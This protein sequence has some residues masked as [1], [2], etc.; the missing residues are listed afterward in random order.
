MA[1][2][3]SQLTTVALSLW[4]LTE[5]TFPQTRHEHHILTIATLRIKEKDKWVKPT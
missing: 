1:E 5:S 2:Y 3:K 4:Q